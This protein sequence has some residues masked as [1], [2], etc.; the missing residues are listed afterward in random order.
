MRGVEHPEREDGGEAQVPDA[1]VAAGPATTEATSQV[2]DANAAE[3]CQFCIR[4]ARRTCGWCNVALC[5]KHALGGYWFGLYNRAAL[6]YPCS[7][8][9]S[10]TT[11]S[12]DDD[13]ETTSEN[14]EERERDAGNEGQTMAS[15]SE[16]RRGVSSEVGAGTGSARSTTQDRA[17]ACL[18]APSS[19]RAACS[20]GE[21]G[22]SEAENGQEIIQAV[23]APQER[24][25]EEGDQ[26]SGSGDGHGPWL[27]RELL[28]LVRA[29]DEEG[30]V[31]ATPRWNRW[32]RCQRCWRWELDL[33]TCGSC[34]KRV[35]PERCWPG[36]GTQCWD[37]V[38]RVPQPAST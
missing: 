4:R 5:R 32:G 35:C 33:D 14:G 20:R 36:V 30:P 23:A 38:P 3:L 28:L 27:S 2:M 29:Q 1:A 19:A 8:Q 22:A 24:E 17:Q 10:D 11:E 12:D 21:R 7:T 26:M 6:C 9:W 16:T 34:Y 13:T 15:L 25:L 37:C 18:G 31:P